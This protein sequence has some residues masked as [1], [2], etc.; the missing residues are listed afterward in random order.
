MQNTDH[1]KQADWT[2][3]LAKTSFYS[4]ESNLKISCYIH[5]TYIQEKYSISHHI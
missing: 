5:Y 2:S 4:F 3:D 1:E